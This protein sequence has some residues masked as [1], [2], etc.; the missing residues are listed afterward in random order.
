M[1]NII[2][3]GQKVMDECKALNIPIGRI[4]QIK[5]NTRASRRWGQCCR[6]PDGYI[7]EIAAILLDDKTPDN[8]LYSTIAHELLHTCPGCMNHDTK[9]KAYATIM[10]DRY[11]YNI[12]RTD[13]AEDKG[14]PAGTKINPNKK[15]EPNR[16]EITCN[17]CG[18]KYYYKREG[19]VVQLMLAKPTTH[20]CRCACGS[21]ALVLKY[22]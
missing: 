6:E 7:I 2:A 4:K 5:I 9:W 1:K 11:G 16:F 10:N 15:E 18:H 19:K 12:K 21:S 17:R 22:L 8:G 14:L 3:A 13:N 20:G